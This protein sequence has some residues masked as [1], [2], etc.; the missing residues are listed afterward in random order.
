MA[1][2]WLE[3]K[4]NLEFHGSDRKPPITSVATGISIVTPRVSG[5]CNSF[6]IVCESVSLCVRLTVGVE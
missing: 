5:G 4:F 3:V 6:D 2:V 1:H